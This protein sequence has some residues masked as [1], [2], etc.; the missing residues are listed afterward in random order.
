VEEVA[1]IPAG[2]DELEDV[3]GESAGWRE[4]HQVRGHRSLTVAARMARDKGERA[5]MRQGIR[6]ATV[7]ERC[8]NSNASSGILP[9]LASDMR[10]Y[11]VSFRGRW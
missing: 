2:F 7:K 11:L 1:G 6:A 5:S 3:E 4:R 8:P 10:Y 9:I